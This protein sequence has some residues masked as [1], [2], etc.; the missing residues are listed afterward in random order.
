M[1]IFMWLGF[2]LCTLYAVTEIA[3]F[4]VKAQRDEDEVK[5][6]TNDIEILFGQLIKSSNEL[7]AA[8]DQIRKLE[9]EKPKAGLAPRTPSVS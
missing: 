5:R 8:Y 3:R 9:G 6:L 2:I 1:H 4:V 7:T